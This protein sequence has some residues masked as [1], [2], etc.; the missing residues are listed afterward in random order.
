LPANKTAAR[1]TAMD[2]ME[3]QRCP[4]VCRCSRCRGWDG[5]PACEVSGGS[6]APGAR[7][8]DSNDRA[9]HVLC[10]DWSAPHQPPPAMAR[11]LSPIKPLAPVSMASARQRLSNGGSPTGIVPSRGGTTA[12]VA[13]S[14]IT[15]RR[16]RCWDTP[17]A[18]AAPRHPRGGRAPLL[19]SRR[20]ARC[21]CA[22]R[23]GAGVLLPL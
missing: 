3:R 1:E 11:V 9:R 19:E 16:W 14:T 21:H 22:D 12:A 8:Q 20:P 2:W 4:V 6:P 5:C 17:H 13:G 18:E 10:S 15:S 7:R 23:K